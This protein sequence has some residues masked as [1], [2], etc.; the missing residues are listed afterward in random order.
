MQNNTPE[1]EHDPKTLIHAMGRDWCMDCPEAR[2]EVHIKEVSLEE[3][4]LYREF[5]N[6]FRKLH[7]EPEHEDGVTCWCGPISTVVEGVH[8]IDHKHQYRLLQNLFWQFMLK[9]SVLKD[10]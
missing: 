1:H 10:K 4:A 8:H 3:M 5:Q 6:A 2:V 7:Y 9:Y